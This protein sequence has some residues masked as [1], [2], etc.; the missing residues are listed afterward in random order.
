MPLILLPMPFVVQVLPAA[1]AP[2]ST[3]RI[4]Y[5]AAP[6][7][8]PTYI[9]YAPQGTTDT[10]ATWT[11]RQFGYDAIGNLVAVK[12]ALAGAWTNRTALTYT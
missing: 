5:G 2:T 10:A 9:G 7:T 12:T 3:I 4:D 11:I 6:A 1:A 8:G